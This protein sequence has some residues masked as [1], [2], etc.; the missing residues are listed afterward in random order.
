VVI[1]FGV[2][3]DI[4]DGIFAN[5]EEVERIHHPQALPLEDDLPVYLCTQPRLPLHEAW[6]DLRRFVRIN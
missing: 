1:A 6:A 2:P 4:L 3:R 5:I